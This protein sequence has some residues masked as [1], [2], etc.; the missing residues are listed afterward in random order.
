MMVKQPMRQAQTVFSIHTD[1]Q[2]LFEFT[3]TITRW[4]NMQ[5]VQTGQVTLFCR[6]TSASLIIQE[7]ADPDVQHD[8]QYYFQHLVPENNLRYRLHKVT[9]FDG[10]EYN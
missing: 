10:L 9:F 2:G 8:L 6:H 5:R 4:L 3:S 1:G 7:N